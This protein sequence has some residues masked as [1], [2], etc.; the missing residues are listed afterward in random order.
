MKRVQIDIS[1]VPRLGMFL[2]FTLVIIFSTQDAVLAELTRRVLFSHWLQH[3]S[4][5]LGENPDMFSLYIDIYIYLL[6]LVLP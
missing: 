2:F 3:L 6:V 5:R 4:G 1:S